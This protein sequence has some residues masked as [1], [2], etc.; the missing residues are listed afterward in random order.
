MWSIRIIYRRVTIEFLRFTDSVK[1]YIV[2]WS[3]ER[4]NIR[5]R[6]GLETDGE[7][8]ADADD[9]KASCPAAAR[10]GGVA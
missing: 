5:T 3:A 6:H 8:A 4:N 2:Y 10:R 7:P 1:L 9:E